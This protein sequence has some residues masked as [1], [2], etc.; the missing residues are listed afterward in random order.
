M[1]GGSHH[2]AL[3]KL[4]I[5]RHQQLVHREITATPE[6]GPEEAEIEEFYRDNARLVQLLCSLVNATAFDPEDFAGVYRHYATFFWA[7]ARGEQTKGHP[8]YPKRGTNDE[9]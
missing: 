7:G 3:E 8:N 6:A 2:A 1:K 4:T 5:L 9:R